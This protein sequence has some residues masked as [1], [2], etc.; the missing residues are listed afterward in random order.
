VCHLQKGEQYVEADQSRVF[1]NLPLMELKRHLAQRD[2]MDE[3]QLVRSF[4]SWVRRC[5]EL[6]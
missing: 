1:P 3:T 2:Q 6:G 4:R 5:F